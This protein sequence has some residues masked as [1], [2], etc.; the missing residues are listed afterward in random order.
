[1]TYCE[2]K[3]GVEGGR[4]SEIWMAYLRVEGG[5]REVGRRCV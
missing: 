1:M 4:E 3:I 2:E 5:R